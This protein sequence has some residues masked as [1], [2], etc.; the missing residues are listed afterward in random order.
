MGGEVT[1]T[2]DGGLHL[3]DN[4]NLLAGSVQNLLQGVQYITDKSI[5][6]LSE[7]INKAS[8][9]PSKLMNLPQQ[10]GLTIGAQADIILFE[11]KPE[12]WTVIETYKNG[13]RVFQNKKTPCKSS[14]LIHTHTDL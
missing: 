9:Y 7:S 3:R 8:V 13:E 12:K 5:S 2:N 10:H 1:L 11:R 14:L 4:P 6:G